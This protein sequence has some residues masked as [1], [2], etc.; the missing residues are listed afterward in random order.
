M[1]LIFE[2]C[3]P[4][5]DVLT[6]DLKEEMFAA[7][8]RDVID[9]KADPIYRDPAVFF[10]HT[11]PTDG[12]KSLLHGALGRLSGAK[13]TNAPIIRLETSFGG[14]KTHNLIGLYHAARTGKAAKKLL[15]RFVDEALL[16]AEPIKQIAGVSAPTSTR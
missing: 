15:D 8:L 9:A 13:P 6:G 16:P 12:F 7:H 4:R 1:K 2:S 11:Y 10:E 14:G 3:Q 5:K